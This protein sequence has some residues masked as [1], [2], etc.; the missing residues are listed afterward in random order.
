MYPRAWQKDSFRQ[1]FKTHEYFSKSFSLIFIKTAVLNFKM[2]QTVGI[3]VS[4]GVFL[5]ILKINL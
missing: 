4:H 5:K 1:V 3:V 2:A